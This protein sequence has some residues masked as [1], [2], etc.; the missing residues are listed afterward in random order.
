LTGFFV[1]FGDTFVDDDD[2]DDDDGE[3]FFIGSVFLG[4][5]GLR[6]CFGDCDGERRRSRRF[7]IGFVL[8]LS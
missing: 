8:D 3:R 7:D 4:F 1:D 6:L 2:D 5:M